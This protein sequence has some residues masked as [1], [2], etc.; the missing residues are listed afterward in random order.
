MRLLGWFRKTREVEPYIEESLKPW[1]RQ[2]VTT[3]L[4]NDV[5]EFLAETAENTRIP[6]GSIIDMAMRR[7][8]K[9]LEDGIGS[10]EVKVPESIIYNLKRSEVMSRLLEENT[11]LVEEHELKQKQFQEQ[12]ETE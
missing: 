6:R 12:E 8:R 9:D 5:I 2:K 4:A 11:Q 3:V 7:F 1:A 10:Q